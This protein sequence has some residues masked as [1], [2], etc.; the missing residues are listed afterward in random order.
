M[1]SYPQS[2]AKKNL[3]SAHPEVTPRGRAR[4]NISWGSQNPGH[5]DSQMDFGDKIPLGCPVICESIV[6][7]EMSR[8]SLCHVLPD[9]SVSMLWM[10]PRGLTHHWVP[11]RTHH[12]RR[13]QERFPGT[14]NHRLVDCQVINHMFLEIAFLGSKILSPLGGWWVSSGP[15]GC[16]HGCLCDLGFLCDSRDSPKE[17]PEGH[18]ISWDLTS[19]H[20]AQKTI[21]V[22]GQWLHVKSVSRKFLPVVGA[23]G[24]TVNARPPPTIEKESGS[25]LTVT[26]L[27]RPHG[28]YPP[29]IS[30]LSCWA[31]G[32]PQ[33]RIGELVS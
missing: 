5:K 9:P 24:V 19:S 14:I 30:S 3:S 2:T 16:G 33:P 15:L 21:T 22:E 32:P 26:R 28:G 17:R 25:G 4:D 20:W 13:E 18:T 7:Q 10:N 6:T 8:L 23:M 11:H 1:K 12:Q 31:S 29:H 27:R